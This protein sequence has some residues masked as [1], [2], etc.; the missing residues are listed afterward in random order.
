MYYVFGSLRLEL[1]GMQ[2]FAASPQQIDIISIMNL[3]CLTSLSDLTQ[4]EGWVKERSN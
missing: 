4:S 1:Q 3:V 2:D